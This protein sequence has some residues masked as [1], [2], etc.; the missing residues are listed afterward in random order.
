V[1]QSTRISIL[2][3]IVWVVGMSLLSGQGARAN[4]EEPM[5][6]ARFA[7]FLARLLAYDTNLKARAGRH[8][9]IAVLYDGADPGAVQAGAD[10]AASI[11][12]LELM[13]ILDLPV[14]THSLAVTNAADLDKAVEKLGI[15]TFIVCPCLD[16][17]Q[18]L[19]KSVS[20]K[21]KVITVGTTST[22]VRS[23]LS[24]A[25]Y[26]ENGKSKILVNLPAS[27]REG[28]AFSSD[29]LRLSEVIQ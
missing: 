4:G 5:P 7:S 25:V 3:I 18:A 27:K 19:I 29:L 10:M 20:E 8:V 23:G 6:T 9:V 26:L 17:Q 11:K 22:Q 15:D 16:K 2:Q 12:T 28:T 21:R 13:R 14:D 24:I 1:K